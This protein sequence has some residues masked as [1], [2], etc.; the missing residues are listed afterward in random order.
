MSH[1]PDYEALDDAW[2]ALNDGDAGRAL[3]IARD[4]DDQL[5]EVWL[6]RA[7]AALD[8][9]Q[10]GDARQAVARAARLEGE[11]LDVLLVQA[12]VDLRDW[13]I[14][15]ATRRLERAL[16]IER[17]PAVLARLA[18]CRDLAGDFCAADGLLEEAAHLDPEN[19][20]LPPRMSD[21]DV[22]RVMEAAIAS[23]PEPFQEA[24]DEVQVS[25]EQMPTREML[26]EDLSQTAP[27]LLGLFTGLS[28]LEGAD[29][30]N[31]ELPP[32]IHLFQRNLERGALDTDELVDE[33]HVT[34]YHEL[35]H[36]LGFDEEG[37]ADMGLE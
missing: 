8:L 13:R 7:T 37:V 29:D 36:Y 22:E 4:L 27:D 24:L 11:E 17:S 5:R 21:E 23:L 12:E 34:L 28:K 10:L 2:Q 3:E 19:F 18:L 33:I 26:G 20:P 30:A 31:L 16:E 1:E 9:D 32:T 6:L 35:A 15:D 14:D 25:V